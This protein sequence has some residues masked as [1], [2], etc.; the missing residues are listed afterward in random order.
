MEKKVKFS[1]NFFTKIKDWDI[2]ITIILVL[3][4]WVKTL[5]GTYRFR[6]G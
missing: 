6:E 4:I 3:Y 2:P 1:K 5:M